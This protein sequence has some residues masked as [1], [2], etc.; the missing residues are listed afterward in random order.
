MIIV[1]CIPPALFLG[2]LLGWVGFLIV[3][4]QRD[5]SRAHRIAAWTCF[6]LAMAMI[7]VPAVAALVA[8]IRSLVG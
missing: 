5:N 7:A 4:E 6:G 2:L 3:A 8:W 1:C